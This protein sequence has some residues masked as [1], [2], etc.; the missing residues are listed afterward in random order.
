MGKVRANV[1]IENGGD[2]ELAR[3][4]MLDPAS[5]RRVDA[6][7]VVDRG[8][9]VVLLPQ[10]MAEA[11]GLAPFENRVVTLADDRKVEMP[12]A[13]PLRLTVFGDR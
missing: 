11:L 3:R 2:A 5:V 8:A 4:G 10:D 6:D 9:V 7:M 1:L 13:G 12:I